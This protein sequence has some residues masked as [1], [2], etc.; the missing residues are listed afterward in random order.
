MSQASLVERLGYGPETRLLIINCDDLG[1]SH[2]ANVATRAAM[3][4]GVATSA[5][6]MVPCPWA[7]E[8]ASMFDRLPVGVHLTLT[9]EYD[10]YRWRGLTGG[11]SLH[12]GDGFLPKTGEAA[13][14]ALDPND[15]RAECQAQIE[16]ALDWNV[17]VTHIDAH[18]SVMESRADLFAVYLD[19]AEAFRLPVRMARPEHFGELGFAGREPAAARGVLCNDHQIYPW[20]TPTCEVLFEAVPDL[21]PGVSE[22]FAHPVRDGAELRAYDTRRADMRA[23]DAAGLTDP[24]LRGLLDQ[25]DVT[26]ISFR[27]I[28]ELQRAR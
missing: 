21:P 3:V 13:L 14:V 12:D 23:A 2:S 5:T 24:A 7:R 28:R 17:D 8:A 25:H 19:L 10:G 16:T 22:I 18:M 11:V 15:A 9:A 6:L 1:S 26:L 20:P 4:D 27:E